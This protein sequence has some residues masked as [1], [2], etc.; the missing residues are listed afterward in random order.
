[1]V[2]EH[3]RVGGDQGGVAPGGR[4]QALQGGGL[5]ISLGPGGGWGRWVEP[6]GTGCLGGS[7]G[8]R[9]GAYG[10]L[11]L[12]GR[13]CL[14]PSKRGRWPWRLCAG[15]GALPPV[16]LADA[17]PPSPRTH[18]TTPHHHT[19]QVLLERVWQLEGALEQ[20]T[21]VPSRLPAAALAGM[22]GGSAQGGGGS[23]NGGGGGAGHQMLSGGHGG[24]AMTG[25]SPGNSGSV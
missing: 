21:G 12:A 20:A 8:W 11:Q 10:W 13:L 5:M 15:C 7:A 18:T 23:S 2:E 6:R 3:N 4:F 24:M 25:G 16:A 9:V 19:P 14:R 22:L 17:C 1:M